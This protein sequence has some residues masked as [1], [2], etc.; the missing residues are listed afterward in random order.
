MVKKVINIPL[1]KKEVKGLLKMFLIIMSI[2]TLYVVVIISLYDPNAIA[3]LD[4]FVEMMPELTTI[5]GMV[6]GA[7]TLIGFIVSY[8]YG[9]LLLVLPLLFIIIAT[10]RLVA[11]YVDKKSMGILLSA[12]VERKNLILT[13]IFVLIFYV[14]IMVLYIF[15]LELLVIAIKIPSELDFK[16]LVTVNFG[17]FCMLF[18]LSG[19]CMVFSCCCSENKL[20]LGFG[21]GLPLLMYLF[22]MLSNMEG[23]AK[24]FKYF[25]LFS[26][27]NPNELVTFSF[28]KTIPI[29]ILLLT[30]I[31]LFIISIFVFNKKDLHI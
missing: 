13:Q 2:I 22:K 21:A 27:F 10:N 3:I 25:T 6:A 11:S 15:I 12:P 30:G 9:F 18:C 1:F 24:V 19:V 26:L 4:A 20:A 7:C 31:G 5:L 14:L 17:L 23:K 29:S 16:V 8:L 28:T